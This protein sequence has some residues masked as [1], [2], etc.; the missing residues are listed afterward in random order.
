M[1]QK[2]CLNINRKKRA[3]CHS[4]QP[5]PLF[6]IKLKK[7]QSVGVE[8]SHTH[9]HVHVH[10]Y[11]HIHTWYWTAPWHKRKKFPAPPQ[12]QNSKFNSKKR[13]SSIQ[14]KNGL[15]AAEAV[16]PE[17][18]KNS[19]SQ[20][21]WDP[22]NNSRPDDL[23]SQSHPQSSIPHNF[24]CR[25]YQYTFDF[26]HSK[27]NCVF[28]YYTK[29]RERELKQPHSPCANARHQLTTTSKH[30]KDLNSDTTRI[31]MPLTKREGD[32]REKRW[33]TGNKRV[34]TSMDV[35]QDDWFKI[36]Q[37]QKHQFWGWGGILQQEQAL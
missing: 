25:G 1:N 11:T 34:T 7:I 9:T 14:K 6:R 21:L 2:L 5:P 31:D 15:I 19:N 24:N 10:T 36:I 13:T 4:S 28:L 17:K 20:G 12:I 22:W 32:G 35:R 26:Q 3:W 23:P 18:G 29:K 8:R 27:K 33:Y 16:F 37:K 30:K